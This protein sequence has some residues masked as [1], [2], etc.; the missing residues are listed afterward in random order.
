MVC[1]GQVFITPVT[2]RNRDKWSELPSRLIKS[3]DITNY[4]WHLLRLWLSRALHFLDLF[5]GHKQ[6]WARV[7]YCALSSSMSMGKDANIR[8]TL[9]LFSTTWQEGSRG[10]LFSN[11]NVEAAQ[12]R[13]DGLWIPLY[14]IPLELMVGFMLVKFIKPSYKWQKVIEVTHQKPPH[15]E[16]KGCVQYFSKIHSFKM[17]MAL[18]GH[19]VFRILF[20][21]LR[22][23]SPCTAWEGL[24]QEINSFH[25]W[26]SVKFKS[27]YTNCWLDFKR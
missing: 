7:V 24:C 19:C 14:T 18:R 26:N 11:N 20:C 9:M 23:T 3:K 17:I 25:E 27:V 16:V 1:C 22:H 5:C 12:N 4:I 8:K 13:S 2:F 10:F 6:V 21:S 15:V